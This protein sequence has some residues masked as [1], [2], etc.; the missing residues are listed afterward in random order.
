LNPVRARQ[1]VVVGEINK[2]IH[3]GAP[4]NTVYIYVSNPRNAPTYISSITRVISGPEGDPSPGQT[5]KAEA[6]FMGQRRLINLRIAE[7]VPNK[8]VR[9]I[10]EGDPEAVVQLKLTGDRAGE[11]TSVALS[12]EATGVPTLFLNALLGGLLSQD[13][14]R[15]KKLMENSPG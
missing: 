1:E 13:M 3:I 7:L 15:L 2:Q 11:N 8:I 12:L 14:V 10:L 9:F 5:W 4:L 6:D